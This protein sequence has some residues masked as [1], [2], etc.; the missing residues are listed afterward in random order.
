VCEFGG[1][2]NWHITGRAFTLTGIENQDTLCNP[3]SFLISTTFTIT[4][5]CGG[6]T[7]TL[8]AANGETGTF[9]GSVVCV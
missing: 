2:F 3:S 8:T 4:G 9:S 1:I 6:G 7:V 5:T